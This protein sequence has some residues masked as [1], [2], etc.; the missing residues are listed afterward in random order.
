MSSVFSG[1]DARTV[2]VPVRRREERAGRRRAEGVGALR[3]KT[4]ETATDYKLT[5]IWWKE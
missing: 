3:A 5:K 1:A 2:M 4:R